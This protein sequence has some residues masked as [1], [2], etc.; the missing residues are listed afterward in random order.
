MTKILSKWYIY[1]IAIVTL[2]TSFC[3]ATSVKVAPKAEER[4]NI[5]IGALNI[6][7]NKADIKLNE[8]KPS[9]VVVVNTN[10][11]HVDYSNFGY[12]FTSFR[13]EMDIYILPEEYIKNNE[14]IVCDYAATLNVTS[15]NE[16]LNE[17]QVYYK[18]NEFYKGIK[19]FDNESNNGL[20]KDCISYINDSFKS[21]Y[22]LFFNSKSINL[23]FL[24]E[25][26]T[27]NAID[28]VR[29]LLNEN[30]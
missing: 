4:L 19:V 26:K 30:I 9:D 6:D 25:S 11:H 28:F 27:S 8:Y 18:R 7:I 12:I 15:F 17:E 5:F 2:V 23:G 3:I 24:N 29:T 14:K 21:D 20:L 10:F 22:Y 1:L 13:P 16:F